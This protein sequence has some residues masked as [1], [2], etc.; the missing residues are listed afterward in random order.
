M[1]RISLGAAGLLFSLF[2]FTTSAGAASYDEGE[3]HLRLLNYNV[4]GL[5][6]IAGGYRNGERF[7]QIGEEFRQM[8]KAGTAP[9]IV[10]LQE[11]FVKKTNDI[12][13]VSG[14]PHVVKGPSSKDAD[15]NGKTKFKILNAGLITLSEYPIAYAEKVAFSKNMCGTWDCFANKGVQVA[16]VEIPDLPFHLPVFNTH[17]QATRERADVRIK[18]MGVMTR[19]IARFLRPG[20]PLMFGGDFNSRPDDASYKWWT[21]NAGMVSTGETCLSGIVACEIADGT[22]PDSIVR[23]DQQYTVSGLAR[24]RRGSSAR[25]K[26]RFDPVHVE[27]TFTKLV[28]GKP[29]SDH[30][31]YQVDYVIRWTREI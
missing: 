2:S 21:D 31:G 13:K 5:P 7:K 20:D 24:D 3:Y 18:Q 19:F 16:Y 23:V 9:Q 10:L 15:E 11:A 26:V 28:K 6:G 12:Q 14:Y 8:R 17:L 27:K 1:K 22:D 4:K 29:L 25:Y 30:L